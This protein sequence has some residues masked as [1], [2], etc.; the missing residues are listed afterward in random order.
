MPRL[1]KSTCS[2]VLFFVV[3]GCAQNGGGSKT[4]T[5]T[6]VGAVAGA[7]VGASVAKNKA[8]GAVL[9]ALLGGLIGNRIGNLL[10]ERDQA[11]LQEST[12][13]SIVTG[14]NQTWTNPETGVQAKTVVKETPPPPP[15]ER[16]IPVLKNKVKQLP[17]LEL[18]GEDYA[19]LTDINVRGGPAAD[20]EIVDQLK[21]G[22]DV[23]VVGKVKGQ[24]WYLISQNGAGSGFVASNL[25]KSLGTATVV[26]KAD[27]AKAAVPDANIVQTPVA[28]TTT[29]R[30]VTQQVKTKNGQTAN[31][32]VKACRGPNG[33]EIVAA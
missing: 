12:Q 8:A 2:L 22:A 4:N 30:V 14:T 13:K 1:P 28:S 9:G 6:A 7:A 15:Q 17:P 27:P 23:H 5:G 18:I 33:W 25:V 16:Q 11:R 10:D 21:R 29:C 3:A 20:Y 19:A 26:A 32:D 24:N 31:Q